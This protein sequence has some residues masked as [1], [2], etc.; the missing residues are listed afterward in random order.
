MRK[1]IIRAF[2]VPAVLLV[3]S[4]APKTDIFIQPTGDAVLTID[5]QSLPIMEKMIENAGNFSNGTQ[6]QGSI[7]STDGIKKSLEQKKIQVLTIETKDFAGIKAKVKI[8][9]VNNPNPSFFNVDAANGTALLNITRANIKEFIDLL[10][11]EEKE[12]ADLLLAPIL[13][14]EEM[15]PKD[16]ENLIKAA[17]GETPALELKRAKLKIAFTC[18]KKVLGI[19]APS[20]S[21]VKKD[22]NKAYAE[23]P[24]TNLLCLTDAIGIEVRYVP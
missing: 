16:Y 4:C 22:G 15:S 17:Y 7:F 3:I 8:R 14:G 23:I 6:K 1:K 12:Y 5:I 24:L 19:T 21:F 2:I 11:A 10:S 20:P 18:P 13:T 9:S